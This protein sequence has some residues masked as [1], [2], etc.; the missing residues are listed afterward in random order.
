MLSA[1]YDRALSGPLSTW[2]N[3]SE[4][5]T[6]R[7]HFHTGSGAVRGSGLR[8][9]I[10][11]SY[12]AGWVQGT[13][14]ESTPLPRKAS[15]DPRC[16][17]KAVATTKPG[18]GAKPKKSTRDPGLIPARAKGTEMPTYAA[19][20][21]SR[22]DGDPPERRGDRKKGPPEGAS[23]KD[24][25]TASCPVCGR[26]KWRMSRK[27]NW[28]CEYCTRKPAAKAPGEEPPSEEEEEAEYEEV[29]VE[30][31]SEYT[32][33]TDTQESGEEEPRSSQERQ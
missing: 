29:N 5:V 30:Q 14:A 27:G 24:E 4:K 22:D 19:M 23:P 13:P 18:T 3:A 25:G 15:A 8:A 26:R 10:L 2:L 12:R 17:R 33:E 6:L 31:E 21:K 9:T 7:C 16:S 32:Y 11:H 1:Q 20:A 28:V